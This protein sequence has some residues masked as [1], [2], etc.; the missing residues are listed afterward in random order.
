[1]YGAAADQLLSLGGTHMADVKITVRENGPFKI[2]APEGTVEMV[3][4]EGNK[5]DLTGK[6]VFSL[7]RCGGSLRKPWCDG[8]HKTILGE[9][10]TG[11]VPVAGKPQ[12]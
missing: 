3:D 5:H 9:A 8:T 6:T 11:S 7:C 1:M 4:H 10:G 2:E 12:A